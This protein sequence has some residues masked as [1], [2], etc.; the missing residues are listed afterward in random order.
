MTRCWRGAIALG[1]ILTLTAVVVPPVVEDHL[2]AGF[3]SA[4][5]PVQHAGVAGAT[6]G[7]VAIGTHASLVLHAP[8]SGTSEA[9]SGTIASPDAPRAPPS[10]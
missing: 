8:A 9:P 3:C 7:V 10:A 5:C 1:I 4:D 6:T 2:E